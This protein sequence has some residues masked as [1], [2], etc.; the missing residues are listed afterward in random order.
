M[1]R[2]IVTRLYWKVIAVFARISRSVQAVNEGFSPQG[3]ASTGP[4]QP[5]SALRDA[6]S[7]L[8]AVTGRLES[9]VESL[10][11]SA[12]SPAGRLI[13][14]VSVAEL[15][16][17]GPESAFSVVGDR[18]A[19]RVAEELHSLGRDVVYYSTE[20]IVPFHPE[21][22]HEALPADGVLRASSVIAVVSGV[23]TAALSAGTLNAVTTALALQQAARLVACFPVTAA[24]SPDSPFRSD[25]SGLRTIVRTVP[26]AGFLTGSPGIAAVVAVS[27]PEA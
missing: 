20:E 27:Q 13:H 10:A 8:G 12:S 5:M 1:L 19:L 3:S 15:S 4:H 17:V 14:A 2:R 16:A 23:P 26:A 22:K 24:H 21:L 25:A 6:V 18:A 11:L 9:R 7:V